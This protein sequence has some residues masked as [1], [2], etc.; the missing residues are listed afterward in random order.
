MLIIKLLSENN[1]K[2]TKK[3]KRKK[4]EPVINRYSININTS[5]LTVIELPPS[6]LNNPDVKKLINIH[7]GEILLSE[8]SLKNAIPEEY[9]FNPKP[10]FNKALLSSLS[11]QMIFL[12]EKYQSVCIVYPDFEPHT[13]MLEIVRYARSFTLITKQNLLTENFKE[14]CFYNY[15]AIISVKETE[16]EINRY[17][18]YA[19]FN[20]TEDNAK[21]MLYLKGLPTLLNADPDYFQYKSELDVITSYGIDNKTAYAAF[22]KNL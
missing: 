12:K 18:I 5:N 9:L 3:R 13:S 17:D 14:D 10:Y 19:D 8:I 20:K 1:K 7:K 2:T 6:E 16:P 4:N 22:Y 15:G 21:L 11:K